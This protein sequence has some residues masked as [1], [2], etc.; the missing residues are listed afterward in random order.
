[1]ITQSAVLRTESRWRM[2]KEGI[3]RQAIA[4]MRRRH[5]GGSFRKWWEVIGFGIHFED[6][7]NMFSW[8]WSV[9]QREEWRMK[10]TSTNMEGNI[11]AGIGV[12]I[13]NLIFLGQI[14][15]A[16]YAPSWVGSW[17]CWSEFIAKVLVGFLNLQIQC[18]DGILGH[19][20]RWDD[21]GNG[22]R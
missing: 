19:A 10:M 22:C 4:T 15:D 1:M 11:G 14:W 18:R 9:R 16:K 20:I 6:K 2:L 13:M 5:A 8:M 7:A 12:I 3:G 21:Q 17:T